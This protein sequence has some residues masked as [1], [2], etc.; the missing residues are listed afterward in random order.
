MRN[1]LS[2]LEIFRNNTPNTA[3]GFNSTGAPQLITIGSGLALSP[4]GVLSS[5]II[6][7][8]DG[9]KTGITV[10]SSG[11]VWTVN[12]NT[13]TFAKMQNIATN[14]ILG[15]ST[16]GTGQVEALTPSIVTSMLDLFTLSTKGLVNPPTTATGKFLR[17]DNTWQT[18]S[19]GGLTG[20]TNTRVLFATGSTTVGDDS[21]FTWNSTDKALTVNT[22]RLLRG[23]IRSVYLGEGAG[24][25][26]VTGI[27]NVGIGYLALANVTS[28]QGNVSLGFGAVSAL[29]TGVEN[30]GIGANALTLLSSGNRN[31][32]IGSGALS[33]C[34][35]SQNT[36]IGTNVMSSLTSGNYNV[37]IGAFIQIQSN[38]SN[39]Q[40]SIQNII[41][42]IGNTNT[43]T[44]VS[45][46]S[47]GIGIAAPTTKLDVD[48]P[49]KV[50]SYTV[51]G[52]PS[53]SGIAGAIIFVSNE[54]GGAVLAFS[55]NTN[56]RR[57]TDRAIIS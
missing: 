45:T 47:I 37:A 41:F 32:G 24:N 54:S 3:I 46:G 17:D 14:S 33:S 25:F 9:D 8:S 53:A 51:A 7:I 42:G 34:T 40:L 28:G 21:T 20:L 30:I 56:W 49:I 13:I 44:T 39:G 4:T 26:T 5:N 31:I 29:T 43:G 18:V 12:N 22:V 36:G 1:E 57:V 48:G 2:P 50:K 10:T 15:R 11:S 6:G 35:G 55:D 16:A 23:A 38:T 19:G 27:D 52:V